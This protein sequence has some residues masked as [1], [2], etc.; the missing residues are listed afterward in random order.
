MSLDTMQF[1][2]TVKNRS[3]RFGVYN[4][5]DFTKALKYKKIIK[6]YNNN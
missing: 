4:I 1:A 2:V 6:K 3:V 5:T